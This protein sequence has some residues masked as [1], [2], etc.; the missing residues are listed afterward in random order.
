MARAISLSF[1]EDSDRMLENSVFLMLKHFSGEI[2]YYKD[3][4]SECDFLVKKDNKII[5]AVQVCWHLTADNIERELNGL[6]NAIKSGLVHN[7]LIVTLNQEES[8]DGIKAIPT[9]KF[10]KRIKGLKL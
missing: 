10:D 5:I 2:Y 7:A 6:K 9:W 3:E 8:F 4:K 1:S